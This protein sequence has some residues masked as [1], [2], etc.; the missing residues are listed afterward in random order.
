[1]SD[2]DDYEQ[3]GMYFT[4][5]LFS[6][7]D[8]ILDL[9]MEEVLKTLPLT[10]EVNSALLQREGVLGATLSCVEAYERASWEEVD[11]CG[12]DQRVVSQAYFEALDWTN[13]ALDSLN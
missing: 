11:S 12:L 8:S 5:G 7:L 13:E 1:M 10:E 6:M 3:R 2:T 4:V 9:S